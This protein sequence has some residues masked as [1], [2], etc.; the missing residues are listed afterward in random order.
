VSHRIA[1]RRGETEISGWALNMSRGGLRAVVEDPVELGEVLDIDIA[2]IALQRRGRIVWTQEEPDG[3]II[4]V[5]FLER[6]QDALEGV[7]L[8]ASVEI[9]P[10]ELARTLE[11]DEAELQRTLAK[12]GRD[13][14]NGGA[15]GAGGPPA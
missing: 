5:S 13:G 6:L 3:T 15:G 14:S 10:G 4:G 7:D 9:A 2:D 11:M 1:F 8:D 12:P